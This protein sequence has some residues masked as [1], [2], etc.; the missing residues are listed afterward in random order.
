MWGAGMFLHSRAR[1]KWEALHEAIE[2][3]PIVV[4]CQNTDPELWFG[5]SNQNGY[6]GNERGFNYSDARKLCNKC[7][8]RQQC[9]EY[10]LANREEFGM[11]GGLS[12][13]QR[14]KI[15]RGQ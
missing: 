12:P 6:T 5:D 8:V 2:N 4:P 14:N 1:Q 11:W 13:Q 9:L 10:A 7:P 15:L 3:A